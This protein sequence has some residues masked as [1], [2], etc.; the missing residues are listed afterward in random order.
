MMVP[1]YSNEATSYLVALAFFGWVFNPQ[2][3]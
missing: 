3:A 1:K 2:D